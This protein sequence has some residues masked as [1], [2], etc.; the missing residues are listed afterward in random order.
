[1]IAPTSQALRFYYLFLL[2]ILD[3]VHSF[4]NSHTI[5]SPVMA[6]ATTGKRK[7]S[8]NKN[9]E[10]EIKR[11]KKLEQ[12][13]EKKAFQENAKRTSTKN[14][15]DFLKKMKSSNAYLGAISSKNDE[16]VQRLKDEAH[17][18]SIRNQ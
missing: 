10:R 15:L 9:T 11:R 6:P 14:V 17:D 16:E 12:T 4:T 5:L 2:G 1:M 3:F 13:D 18:N 7:L 8:S